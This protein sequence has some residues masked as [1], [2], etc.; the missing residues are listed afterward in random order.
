MAEAM[1]VASPYTVFFYPL[2]VLGSYTSEMN[3]VFH[4]CLNYYS[5][6]VG[7]KWPLHASNRHVYLRMRGNDDVSK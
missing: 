1:N 7:I 4:A 5:V 3:W 2:P 6:I